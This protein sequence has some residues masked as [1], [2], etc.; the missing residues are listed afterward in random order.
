MYTKLFGAVKCR[1]DKYCG[2]EL[3][4]SIFQKPIGLPVKSQTST[5]GASAL[6]TGSHPVKLLDVCRVRVPP[7]L[8]KMT[9]KP[10]IRY[11]V[12]LVTSRNGTTKARMVA[13][14]STAGGG[15]AAARREDSNAVVAGVAH[16]GRAALSGSGG[17]P[18]TTGLTGGEGVLHPASRRSSKVFVRLIQLLGM[19]GIN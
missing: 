11:S 10:A 14:G 18:A 12:S 16:S 3:L 9:R 17:G 4:Y 13:G 5:V 2:A 15:A 8:L 1:V 19:L 7:G 6:L